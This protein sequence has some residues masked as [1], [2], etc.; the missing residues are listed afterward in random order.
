M[1]IK[2]CIQISLCGV[3]NCW[4]PLFFDSSSHMELISSRKV[5]FLMTCLHLKSL[6]FLSDP[7]PIHRKG[8][9]H[10]HTL[11]LA[12]AWW[13]ADNIDK[14]LWTLE[15]WWAAPTR[16]E[17]HTGLSCVISTVWYI[18][19]PLW[20]TWCELRNLLNTSCAGRCL[21]WRS[22]VSCDP[23]TTFC[24]PQTHVATSLLII[25]FLITCVKICA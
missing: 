2:K 22:P 24:Q 16:M 19:P 1:S 23:T 11:V 13:A 25:V 20:S 17:I 5:E 6:R 12:H 7:C 18:S 10:D 15:A 4:S 8:V 3:D 21:H 14:D 9:M